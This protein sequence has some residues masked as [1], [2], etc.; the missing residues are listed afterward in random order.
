MRKFYKKVHK[1]NSSH[2]CSEGQNGAL[3]TKFGTVVDLIN[4]LTNA[5]FG[6]YRLKGGHSAASQN[7]PI[8]HGFNGWLYNRQA[9]TCCRA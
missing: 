2:P 8:P 6:R 7:L 4:I 1:C 5:N 3:F 9:L